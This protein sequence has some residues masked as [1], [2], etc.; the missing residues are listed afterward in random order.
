MSL[1]IALYIPFSLDALTSP[2]VLRGIRK[3]VIMQ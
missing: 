1:I 2:R 3:A